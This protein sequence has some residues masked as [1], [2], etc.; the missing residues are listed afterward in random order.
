MNLYIACDGSVAA[1]DVATGKKRWSTRLDTGGVFSA[2]SLEDVC[3]LQHDG[4]VFVG[5]QGHVFALDT[6]TGDVL[7]H[8][9]LKGW[10]HNDVTLAIADKSVQF[11]TKHERKHS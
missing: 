6:E 3:I 9:S 5:C 11:V 7:W 8:N 2:T 4:R 10:G 1:L